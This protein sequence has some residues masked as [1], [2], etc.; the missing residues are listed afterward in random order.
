MTFLK[1]SPHR[2]KVSHEI[3]KVSNTVI[4][5]GINRQISRVKKRVAELRFFRDREQSIGS[6]GNDAP[7]IL[8]WACWYT[9]PLVTLFFS[10]KCDLCS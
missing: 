4:V 3:R 2:V 9:G 5:N 8:L 10:R 1:L 6:N 7:L